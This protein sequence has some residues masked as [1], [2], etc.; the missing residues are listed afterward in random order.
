MT[1]PLT[2]EREAATR[3]AHDLDRWQREA[4][5]RVWCR[6]YRVTFTHQVVTVM[7]RNPADAIRAGLELAG[8]GA[9]L[10]SC[11]QEGEW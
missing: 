1:D 4:E 10:L 7:A 11:L 5:Q 8:P 3:R 6:P 2:P 9:Q